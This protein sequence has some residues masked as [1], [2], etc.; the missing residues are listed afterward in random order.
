M[1]T[2]AEYLTVN[3]AAEQLQVR[4]LTVRAWIRRNV[5]KSV[6]IGRTV[7]IHKNDLQAAI[8]PRD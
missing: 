7:R 6:R 3:Q 8:R 2:T 4:P 5:I 1:N